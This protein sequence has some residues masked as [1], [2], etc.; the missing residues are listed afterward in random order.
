MFNLR[1]NGE[2]ISYKERSDKLTN[3]FYVKLM[4]LPL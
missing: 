1:A 2:N 3:H 4:Q